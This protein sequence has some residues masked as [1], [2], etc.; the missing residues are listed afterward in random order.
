MANT[1]DD[2]DNELFNRYVGGAGSNQYDDVDNQLYDRYVNGNGPEPQKANATPTLGDYGKAIGAGVAE[3]PAAAASGLR[4][5]GADRAADYLGSN[6]KAYRE[7]WTNQMT[8]AGKA[9]MT[10]PLLDDQGNLQNWRAIPMA[11]AESLPGTLAMGGIGKLASIPLKAMGA[12]EAIAPA[13]T[14]LGMGAPRA[15]GLADS[16]VSGLAYGGAEGV[17]SGL[18]NAEQKYQE[19]QQTPAEQM[20]LNPNYQAMMQSGMSD[21]EARNQLGT[22]AMRDVF[23]R[24]ALSTGGISALTGGG[25]FGQL[26][27]K[28]GGGL[29]SR[30]GKGM[31]SEGVLQEGPQSFGE[32]VIGNLATQQYGNPNQGTF[33]GTLNEALTGLG[34]G[35]LMGGAAGVFTGEQDQPAITPE[36]PAEPQ[37]PTGLGSQWETPTFT[38]RPN[39]P[40]MQPEEAAT[41][42]NPLTVEPTTEQPPAV[43]PQGLGSRWQKPAFT[44]NPNQPVLGDVLAGVPDESTQ[45]SVAPGTDRVGSAGPEAAAVDPIAAR[46]PDAGNE[47]GD[48][49]LSSTRQFNTAPGLA[50]DPAPAAPLGRDVAGS[51]GAEAGQPNR[52]V[53]DAGKGAV[54]EAQNTGLVAETPQVEEQPPARGREE[55]TGTTTDYAQRNQER[56]NRIAQ[57]STQ[58]EMDAVMQ[59]EASDPER[60]FEGYN[61]VERA[62]RDRQF[63]LEQED[64]QQEEQKRYEAGEWTR[65]NTG[66]MSASYDSA[67]QTAGRLQAED[68]DNE[69]TVA[70]DNMDGWEVRRRKLTQ[71]PTNAAPTPRDLG[72]DATS[73]SGGS[74]P[75]GAG[76]LGVAGG[77]EPAG[78]GDSLSGTGGLGT[79]P[80]ATTGSDSLDSINRPA[81]APQFTE[82]D[83]DNRFKLTNVTDLGGTEAVRARLKEAGVKVPGSALDDNTLQFHSS[84]RDDILNALTPEPT[85]DEQNQLS[86]QPEQPAR[87]EEGTQAQAQEEVG[88]QKSQLSERLSQSEAEY[89]SAVDKYNEMVRAWKAL[90]RSQRLNP[91][92]VVEE[93][94]REMLVARGRT[95]MA[96]RDL[97]DFSRGEEK[98]QKYGD[99]PAGTRVPIGGPYDTD[100]F[101]FTKQEDGRW[102]RTWNGVEGDVYKASSEMQGEPSFSPQSNPS[103][104]PQ[105]GQPESGADTAAQSDAPAKAPWDDLAARGESWKEDRWHNTRVQVAPSM[106]GDTG[107][108][109]TITNVIRTT[110]G[111]PWLEVKKDGRD[112]SVRVKPDRITVLDL[113]DSEAN[114]ATSPATGEVVTG[115]DQTVAPTESDL[116]DNGLLRQWGERWQTKIGGAWK[117]ATSQESAIETATSE[118][119]KLKGSETAAGQ[120]SIRD[121]DEQERILNALRASPDNATGDVEA[122]AK[123]FFAGQP[124]QLPEEYDGFS[125]QQDRPRAWRKGWESARAN[126]GSRPQPTALEAQPPQVG[127]P[128]SDIP[129]EFSDLTAA[130]NYLIDL[131]TQEQAQGRVSDARLADRIKQ[132]ERVVKALE[133]EQTS[134]AAQPTEQPQQNLGQKLMANAEKAKANHKFTEH[135][136]VAREYGFSVGADGVIS[137]GDK[138]TGVVVQAKKG[139]LQLRNKT[140]DQIL[141]S[142][143]GGPERLSTFLEKFWYAEKQPAQAESE[144]GVGATDVAPVSEP[145]TAKEP[146]QMTRDEF[147]SFAAREEALRRGSYGNAESFHG[148]V[149]RAALEAGKPVP[150]NVLAEYPDLQASPAQPTA[151]PRPGKRLVSQKA[152]EAAQS[153][154]DKSPDVTDTSSA[155]AQ[156]VTQDNQEQ[157]N[158][159]SDQAERLSAR[160]S[161]RDTADGRG[162]DSNRQSVDT[163]L[164]GPRQETDRT[165]RV[166]AGAAGAVRAGDGRDDGQPGQLAESDR[167]GGTVRPVAGVPNAQNVDFEIDAEDIGK[168][169][170]TVKYRDN[171][172]ALKILKTLESDNRVATPDERKTLA[173]YVGWG[174]LKGVFDPQNKTWAK[175]HQEL[176]A[177]LTPEEWESALA[178][179]LNAHYTAPGVVKTMYQAM[180]RL[181]F[182][183]GYVLEPAMGS[184]NFFGL[185]PAKVRQAS[186]L[187]GVELDNL[188]SRLAKALYPNAVIAASTGFQD[189]TV[190]N[191]YFDLAIGN[192]PFGSERVPTRERTAYVGFSIHNYFLARMIDKVREG[193]IVAAVVSHNFMDVPNSKAR[194]WIAER[195]N[196]LG[197]VRLPNTAFKGN[198]GTEVVTDIVF[199]QKT[200]NPEAKPAWVNSSAVILQDK[201]GNPAEVNVNDYFRA[202][203]ENVLGRETAAGT[204]YR[205]GEYDVE[206]TG[207]LDEQLSGFVEKL[208]AGVYQPGER[209]VL[210]LDSVDNTVPEQIKVGSYYVDAGGQVRQRGTDVAGQKT[211][212]VWAAPNAKARE[213]MVG[214]IQLRDLLR[215]QLRLERSTDATDAAIEANRATLQKAYAQFK[216][217]YGYL[218]KDTNRR[219][220]VWDTDAPLLQALEFDYEKGLSKEAAAK[221]NR[222]PVP[223]S[224]KDADI[225]SRR[226]LFPPQE[227]I[228]VSN[229][230]DALL[231][232]LNIKGRIDMDYLSMVYGKPEAEIVKELGDAVYQSPDD[233]SWQTAD[234]Y[235]SG[236]VKTKLEHAKQAAEGN[237]A[238]RRNV[239][240]LEK[241]IP[242]DKLPSEIYAGLGAGWIPKA[243]VEAFA[244]EISGMTGAKVEYLA[245][246]A[247]WLTSFDGNGSRDLMVN[248]FG[249]ERMDSLK[250]LAALLNG[251]PVEVKDRISD[252]STSSGYRLVANEAETE[253][254]KAKADKIKALWDSWLFGDPER[255]E[256][257]SALFNEKFNR[258]VARGF[259]GQ[260]LTL[261]GITPTLELRKHQKDVIWRGIQERNLLLD[262]VVG[263]GKTYA[264]VATVMEMKRLGIARKPLVTVPNHLTQQWKSD[265]AR[266]YP[267]ANVLAAEPDDFAKGNR[268]RLFSKIATG[269]WDAV[270]IGHSSLKKVGLEPEIEARFLKQ[271]LNEIAEAIESIKRDRGDRN[272]IRDMEKIKANLDAKINDLLSKAGER[273]KVLSF[274]ELGIDAMVVD[275]HHEFKNLFFTT[276]KQRVSGLGNPKGS[277]KAFDLFFKIRWLQET[278]GENAPL[279]TATGTPVS[280]SL[281]EMYTMQRY[282]RYDELKR[283]GIH[284]FDAWANLYG[285]DEYVYEVAPSGVGYRIS[286]RFAKFKN[287][288]SLMGQYKQFADVVTLQDL[289]DQAAERGERFPVPKIEGGKP[290]NIVAARSDLQRKFFGVPEIVQ[291]DG[292][293]QYE[294]QDPA[295][296]TIENTAEGKFVLKAPNL[297]QT[298]ETREEAE[299]ALVSKAVTP[300]VTIDPKSIVGQFENLRQLTKESKG[301]INALSLTGLASKAG[302]DMRL[303]DPSAPDNPGSKINK[304]VGEM[305]RLY[306]QWGKDKG[307]QLVFCDLSVP[308]SA[309]KA[310]ASQEKRV[311]VRDAQ[312]KLMHKRGTL[313]TVEG[314]EGLP[315]YLVQTGKGENRSV[316]VYEAVSGGAIKMDLPSKAEALAYMKESLDQDVNRDRMFDL[317]ERVGA[318]TAE[319]LAEYRDANDIE[320]DGEDEFS[321]DDL[322]SYSGASKFSVYDDIKAKLI[323]KGVPENEIAF[324]HDFNT[325]KQKADL[326]KR[327]NRG[328]VRFLLGSTPKLGAGTNVQQKLVGL[329]HIDAPWRPSDLEQREGRIIRQGNTLYERDPDG[330]EVFIGRYATEQTYDTR[331][332]Q[333]I[334][335]KAA[336]IEQL[337][338]YSGELE[339]EDVGGEA[340]NAADMKAAASGN[341]LILE[342]TRLRNEVKRLT[343]LQKAD[344]DGK[345][346]AQSNKRAALKQINEGIP[347][348]RKRYQDLIDS[349]MPASEDSKKLAG[350]ALDGKSEVSREKALTVLT[351]KVAELRKMAGTAEVTYRGIRFEIITGLSGQTHLNA[352]MAQIGWWNPN[353]DLSV[354]GLITRLNNYVE[355]LPSRLKDLDASLKREQAEVALADKIMAEPFAEAKE[356]EA[357]RARHAEVQRQLMKSSVMDAVP[358]DA[359]A[360]FQ[361]ERAERLETLKKLGYG[362]AVQELEG[363][364]PKATAG[365]MLNN[366]MAT[367]AGKGRVFAWFSRLG[368]ENS[369]PA[370]GIRDAKSII[371]LSG[372]VPYRMDATLDNQTPAAVDTKTGTLRINPR[373]KLSRAH[374]AQVMV[375]EIMH[376]VDVVSPGRSLSVGSAR[377]DQYSGDIAQEAMRVHAS[378]KGLADFLSYPL[379]TPG[380]SWQ[381]KRAELFARLAVIYHGDPALMQRELPIAYEA[382]HVLFGATLLSPDSRVLRDVQ[383][384][385]AGS[386]AEIRGRER[387]GTGADG[388]PGRSNQI[389]NTHNGLDSLRK[390]VADIFQANPRG[391]SI[392]STLLK[393]INPLEAENLFAEADATVKTSS[394][395]QRAGEELEK[396]INKLSGTMRREALGALTV[397]Q[398]VETGE[399]LLPRMK[400]Y[401]R[402]MTGMDVTRN[403]VLYEVDGIAKGWESLDAK[404]QARL[405]YVMHESTIAGVDG[406]EAYQP[407]IDIQAA[408]KRIKALKGLQLSAGGDPRISQWQ[409]EAKELRTQIANERNRLKARDRINALYAAL[410]KEAKQV[411]K[412]ARDYHVGQSKRVENALVTMI[413]KSMLSARQKSAAITQLRKDFES[414][415][416]NAPYFPLGRD[417]DYW[418]SVRNADGNGEFVMF[419]TIEEQERAVR[420]YKA[421]GL[422]VA[423]Y[424]KKGQNLQQV[425]G[426]SASFVADVENLIG[427]LGAGLPQ[428]EE[429]RDQVYQLYLRTLPELSSRKHF[430]HRQKTP[431]FGKDALRSFV[432]KGY[433]D[434]YQYARVK[435]G[436]DL[437]NTMEALAAD[438][439]AAT[440]D[441]A[442]KAAQTELKRWSTF[443]EEVLEPG[444]TASEVRERADFMLNRWI[445]VQMQSEGRSLSVGER[446]VK[447]EYEQWK[448]FKEWMDLGGQYGGMAEHVERKMQELTTRIDG[449]KTIRAER[450]GYETAQNYYEELQQAYETLMHPASSTWANTVNQIGYLWHLAF[451]PAAWITNA[452]Q[453]PLI[454]MP[455]VASK[456]G[457]GKTTAAFQKA[458]KEAMQGATKGTKEHALGIRESLSSKDE[459][460]AYDEA[461]ERGLIERGR[462]MDLAGLAEEGA[463]RS[464]WHRK[465]ATAMT[466]GFHDAERLNREV[467]FMAS[468]RLAKSDGLSHEAAVDYAAK[469]V[470]DTHFNYT[471]ENRPRFLRGDIM[472]VL[473]Q[474]KLYSQHVTYLQWRALKQ[475]LGKNASAAEKQEARR[476]L[477]FQTGVQLAAGGIMGL[478][479]GIWATAA[480]GGGGLAVAN[481]YGWKGAMAYAAT[482][483]AAAVAMGSGDDDDPKEWEAEFQQA[484]ADWLGQ[485]GGAAVSKGIINA[486]GGIDLSTRVSQADL[487]WRG[488]DADIGD[489]Q[490]WGEVLSQA[491]GA[492][493]G[494]IPSFIQGVQMARDGD[495][496][497]GIEKMT[498]KVIKDTMQSLRFADEGA[499]T[500]KGDALVPEFA[501]WELAGKAVGF[502]P[503]RL[504][505]RYEENRAEKNRESAIEQRR[506]RILGDIADGRIAYAKARQKG[507][508]NAMQAA[509]ED[510]KSGM[511]A[512]AQFNKA[513]PRFRITPDSIMK[514]VKS[515]NQ[516]RAQ[517]K[518]GVILNRKI[519][520]RYSFAE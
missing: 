82:T 172:A 204:M 459:I 182:K 406:S 508:Q 290:Q 312:G 7:D 197:A 315:F 368:Y 3:I 288:P 169:G 297:Q 101:F 19:I 219:L 110:T 244:R 441:A 160:D 93:A 431:G 285:S 152:K 33:E 386:S 378:N 87:Q 359:K 387:L 166:S 321:P 10:T 455:F 150:T 61:S 161:E 89:A 90:P 52:N 194:E 59:D 206:P 227:N 92:P 438:V 47:P 41:A 473:G 379:S 273:D 138:P 217:A 268:E 482:V 42:Q 158:A 248:E 300:K 326:F 301:K 114:A 421:Q 427:E 278:F 422:Q 324:I 215:E 21:A 6:A 399:R 246:A 120:L 283:Q 146:W 81:L 367:T 31:L 115:G 299:L 350:F 193:G 466:F 116:T 296:A 306:K 238:Y 470:N 420:D 347:A 222:E 505:A 460:D 333:I 259:S 408:D 442:F 155:P 125:A 232:S 162:R 184:G 503:S 416:V 280:N 25:M 488:V 344:M 489:R 26:E 205:G 337:R 513:N 355:A 361:Q 446:Y 69:Y 457:M 44:L 346:R 23:G 437:R 468:Y 73:L 113:K 477:L 86:R 341:P 221:N 475:A 137:K 171:V 43:E 62:I 487:W 18:G 103:A 187:H 303:I 383:S 216:K 395:Q 199:F 467:S 54:D 448:Q 384:G 284:L 58:D 144:A 401:L 349:V 510:V 397:Q 461:M 266:L 352:P 237:A 405:A 123:A 240:A 396:S 8:A 409:Q 249:T 394:A 119:A 447:D 263:A 520:E 117:Y 419:D 451:S 96:S 48:G 393:T 316:A 108:E 351:K 486:I 118:W 504:A 36:Q 267:A 4:M 332:W 50:T 444:L 95:A 30:V 411:Y 357:T 308:L 178:S 380:L 35:A 426:V 497:R 253:K 430:I 236:D 436:F 143:A 188:T 289:K 264:A 5:L 55:V 13:L 76:E 203:P 208:P 230:Q 179:T 358:D 56:I 373:F 225:L 11:A 369:T 85:N 310:A 207:K 157:N 260:H 68:P 298:F 314:R 131:R 231:A 452:T 342:E 274:N 34:A 60:H 211:S 407:V 261:P 16:A 277:G 12:A 100:K 255:A 415:R 392:L 413:Q 272:I 463:D 362:Q 517:A 336:G 201:D 375:E 371:N 516:A 28:V 519:G 247:T 218:N 126:W 423:G 309:K 94:K 214:M 294:L 345:A 449:A 239:Q 174:A 476:F 234:E 398:L 168:G 291:E 256:R 364:T 327:M 40:V 38:L 293:T 501:P 271:Q 139:R 403:K 331:R 412:Q 80:T 235:L 493:L 453:T 338:K 425:L 287:L 91:D 469:V 279:I 88:K 377:F 233:E 334:E 134:G 498:P 133:A 428:V 443:K 196:L 445:D 136:T 323:R 228:N 433:H 224:A 130:R 78:R 149:V 173:K 404:T 506:S 507:D 335:H 176:K 83:K 142:Y 135:D 494:T 518:D 456:F 145:A 105:A 220:F 128:Q 512:M 191:D 212:T 153:A 269:D 424:G 495:I 64:K 107:W 511:A 98:A 109:G 354:S 265:F 292:Q 102:K 127:Q 29:L 66:I 122:G 154:P 480:V 402:D 366:R 210:D 458:Y 491:S 77:T 195:A 281:A 465:F 454:T 295:A 471:A 305:M 258:T 1:Y 151:E 46:G 159:T 353:E 124:K 121:N 183:G 276:Q 515:R 485:T 439:K 360:A 37:Q 14:R 400:D 229:A 410:P 70:G 79:E 180:D 167:E 45:A 434:A 243:D 370:Q 376:M 432:K 15:A 141:A 472:R 440:S 254:A 257:L 313:H 163:G 329:H 496:W 99:M 209:S 502:Q 140:N 509:Q 104:A 245:P 2:L 223:E 302:L 483:I 147:K 330:F 251:K 343:A 63:A 464:A 319:D 388:R 132:Q 186:K 170:L 385:S 262:H 75:T 275:E 72:S 286:Q 20:E 213:R 478:P 474:F 250:I 282:M 492:G 252:P 111:Q 484:M 65:V 177:M 479:L 148:V 270:V 165:G 129:P 514:S 500:M 372:P 340:A 481:R 320:T 181:G 450:R 322:E 435:H 389:G 325:P 391:R 363:D 390:A 462:A 84:R 311:Y 97:H 304:A 17:F 356:L 190:P 414:Q 32:S 192:P 490:Y 198:A 226:V 418:V 49:L 189:Y 156:G 381:G 202:N 22:Q 175:Q 106:R 57:A 318:I 365:E 339:I 24:T 185:M 328:E 242:K 71:E 51:P 74:R 429:I 499:I 112:Y 200:A 382:Y 164:A 39:E 53:L 374:W 9:A 348:A 307:A 317:R 241:V 417:G 27:N 67:T